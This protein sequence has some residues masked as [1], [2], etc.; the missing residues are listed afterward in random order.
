MW[1]TAC[2]SLVFRPF[3]RTRWNEI[4]RLV[5]TFQAGRLRLLYDAARPGHIHFW[6]V[7]VGCTFLGQLSF[8]R[9][10]YYTINT[11]ER[12][13]KSGACDTGRR[14][15]IRGARGAHKKLPVVRWEP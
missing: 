6:F 2:S 10:Y 12:L 13:R 11:V 9:D 1:S 7:F 15:P 3:A 4:F 14:H 8:R 5:L